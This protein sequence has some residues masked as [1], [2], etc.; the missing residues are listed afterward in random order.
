MDPIQADLDAIDAALK[1]DPDLLDDTLKSKLNDVRSNLGI[2]IRDRSN[3][4]HNLD[5]ALEIMSLASSDLKE[6]KAAVK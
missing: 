3:G 6:I 4:A 5:Y 1:E 2:I